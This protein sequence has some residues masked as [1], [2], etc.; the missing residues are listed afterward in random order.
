MNT[1]YG[2][3]NFPRKA[4][5]NNPGTGSLQKNDDQGVEL[6]QLV[7]PRQIPDV[8][9]Q[10]LLPPQADSHCG[11]VGVSSEGEGTAMGRTP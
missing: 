9:S 3:L 5:V 2:H 11:A 6:V 10:K 8:L 4:A 1:R 7:N